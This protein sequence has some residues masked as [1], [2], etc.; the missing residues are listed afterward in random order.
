MLLRPGLIASLGAHDVF[1][2]LVMQQAGIEM[3]F[4]GGFGVAASTLGLPDL[5]LITLTEMAEAVRRMTA[6]VSIPV[7][8]D[9]DTGHGDLQNVVR[10]VRELEAAGAAGLLL[11][12]QVHPKRC[13]HIA[14]KDV[15]AA[16]EM[17]LKLRAAL[18]TRRDDDFVIFARTDALAVAGI[19]AAIERAN[20]YAD[21]GA[22]VCFVEGPTTLEELERIPREVPK[23]LLANMLTGGVTPI[24]SFSELERMGYKIG[25]C[26]IAG[27]LATGAAIKL[28]AERL[29]K[30]GQVNVEDG[31]LMTFEE[32]KRLL[33]VP[34]IV[35]LRERLES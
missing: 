25:V 5:G 10:T 32:V 18:D 3:L 30:Q 13:G 17:C 27:L 15:I 16:E 9:G 6:Q 2:A 4:A 1:S 26:P 12:D 34:E 19:D 7:V 21:Q 35:S 28:C 22:D 20:L 33:G 11:E 14:G 8:A 23:P 31:S 29:R 24:V